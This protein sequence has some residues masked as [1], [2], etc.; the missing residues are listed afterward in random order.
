MKP[1]GKSFW[2][3]TKWDQRRLEKLHAELIKEIARQDGADLARAF[4]EQMAQM[5]AEEGL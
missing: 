4:H 5:N 2:H 1:A 3:W